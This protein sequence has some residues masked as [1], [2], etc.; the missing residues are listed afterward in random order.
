MTDDAPSLEEL[1]LRQ[2]YVTADQ[3]DECRRVQERVTA[4]GLP[5]SLDK[6]KLQPGVWAEFD[7][8][9]DKFTSNRGAL[10]PH[11]TKIVNLYIMAGFVDRTPDITIDAF[12]VY[13][14]TVPPGK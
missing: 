1:A 5:C 14:P 11:D 9:L 10:P 4:D 13:D 8:P 12:E 2:G 6:D 7:Q 3:L